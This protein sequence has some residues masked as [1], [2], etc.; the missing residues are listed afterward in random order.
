MAASEQELRAAI[1]VTRFGMG[2]RLGEIA[3]ATSDPRGWLAAQIR[4][5]GADEPSFGDGGRPTVAAG[6]LQLAAL[7]Q[8]SQATVDPE[9]RKH[10][11]APLKDQLMI[12]ALA[13]ARLAASTPAGFRERWTLFWCNHFTVAAKRLD[14]QVAVGP[15]EREAIRPNVFGRFQDLLEASTRHPGM[16]LY[17]DQFQSIGPDS[18]AAG[19]QGR[20]GLN[21]NLAREILELHTVGP[22]AGY[23]QSDVTEFAR[24][25]TGWSM[26]GAK[27]RDDERGVFVYRA[28][29]HEPGPRV[30]MGRRYDQTDQDQAH[31]ILAD[32][33]NDPRTSRRIA[34]KL[35][36]HFVADDPPPALT[37]KLD[38]AWRGSRGDM[39][40]VARALIA[41]P[42]AW[43]PR[44]AKFKTPYEFVISAYRAADVTPEDGFHDVG[45]PLTTLGQRPFF[46]PQ[47][48]GWSDLADDWAAPDA[49]VKRLTWAQAFAGARTPSGLPLD[50]AQA[51][52]GAR[53]GETTRQAVARA[54]TRPEAFTILLLSP[55]FQRR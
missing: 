2:A 12:E 41:S 20:G 22:D 5:D 16:L 39:A 35:A 3:E 7:R 55:E 26:G 11:M 42:E 44:A 43:A 54:E 17:L 21:E 4:H 48:N 8:Q 28:A 29:M 36:A 45:G 6:M 1:A 40:A 13:K 51:A 30:I 47:P 31:A 38:A 15:F 27:S 52:L 33:A 24:A 18:I 9:T 46:A 49:I 14:V 19:R 10:V 32:L 50:V 53:L 23:T 37:A 34:R 25:L